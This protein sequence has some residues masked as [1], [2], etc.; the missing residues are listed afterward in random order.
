MYYMVV[1]FENCLAH[2]FMA[3]WI[4]LV[5]C[6]S[7]KEANEISVLIAYYVQLS[8]AQ[9]NLCSCSFV[10]AFTAPS[11]GDLLSQLIAEHACSKLSTHVRYSQIPLEIK[12]CY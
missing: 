2:T 7:S 4:F 10:R 11:V 5:P 12:A 9:T 1:C 3:I 8:K 6:L